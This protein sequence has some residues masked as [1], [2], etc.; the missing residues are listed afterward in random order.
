MKYRINEGITAS[1]V[2]V[3]QMQDGTLNRIYTL[4]EALALA[5]SLEK[6]L[7]EIVPQAKPPVCR[8]IEL[9]K[10]MYEEKKKDKEKKQSQKQAEMKEIRFGPQTDD[11][12]FDF[13]TKHAYEFLEKG[14]KVRA[15]VL[16]RGRS[17][18]YKDQGFSILERFV[19]AL[20][21]VGKVETE[22]K[23]EGKKAT[24]ILVP[25]GTKTK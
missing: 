24:V 11:H 15:F 14:H 13:K 5:T 18:V 6:D 23:M 17:I 20:E 16:F 19:K 25:K 2:R 7:I 1:E 12:D 3:V 22:P 8:I 4:E 21:E 9:S 10:L